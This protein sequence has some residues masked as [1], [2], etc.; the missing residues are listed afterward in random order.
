[1]IQN[2]FCVL[3]TNPKVDLK[4]PEKV[5]LSISVLVLPLNVARICDSYSKN[6][7]KLAAFFA[8]V[9]VK[10]WVFLVIYVEERPRWPI[11]SSNK[12]RK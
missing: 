7:T 4:N 8:L 10:A 11:Q 12:G 1:M 5:C 6:H 2:S 3:L 9:E